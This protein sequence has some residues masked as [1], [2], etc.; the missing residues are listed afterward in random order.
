MGL[1]FS[2]GK[3]RTEVRRTTTSKHEE[4]LKGRL[5]VPPS[6]ENPKQVDTHLRFSTIK[7]HRAK[8]NK[9]KIRELLK[10]IATEFR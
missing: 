7:K 3:K 2:R 10:I 6:E 4:G 1:E 8:W 5:L 9:K